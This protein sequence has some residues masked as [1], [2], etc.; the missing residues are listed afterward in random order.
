[1]REA[2]A[3]RWMREF[4]STRVTWATR[5]FLPRS[6]GSMNSNRA[7]TSPPLRMRGESV[8]DP[9]LYFENNV[10]Q[11]VALIG[12]LLQAGEQPVNPKTKTVACQTAL[13]TLKGAEDEQALPSVCHPHQHSPKLP[14]IPVSSIA[15]TAN[16]TCTF[17]ALTGH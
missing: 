8:Q 7:F 6:P 9:K 15:A 13:K 17:S 11:G 12:S 10:Q 1:L 3:R 4:P 14:Q 5:R 16:S 2:T